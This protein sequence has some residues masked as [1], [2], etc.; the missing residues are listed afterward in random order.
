[1]VATKVSRHIAVGRSGGVGSTQSRGN[2]ATSNHGPN[3]TPSVEGYGNGGNTKREV[4]E[5]GDGR[6]NIDSYVHYMDGE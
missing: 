2:K 6:D 4:R 1:M 5:Q 3:F